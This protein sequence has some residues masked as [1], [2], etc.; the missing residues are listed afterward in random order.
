MPTSRKKQARYVTRKNKS[1][2][3]CLKSE[4]EAIITYS[5]TSGE[6]VGYASL[7]GDKVEIFYR[8][9]PEEYGQYIFVPLADAGRLAKKI[10]KILQ[11][12]R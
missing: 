8:R 4:V 7:C 12:N 5:F 10:I 1:Q 9:S 6:A 11:V 2:Q 3:I